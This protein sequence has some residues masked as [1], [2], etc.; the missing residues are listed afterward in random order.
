MGRI[1]VSVLSSFLRYPRQFVFNHTSSPF[2]AFNT[3]PIPFP[4]FV[5]THARRNK[6]GLIVDMQ[7]TGYMLPS[8]SNL[9]NRSFL[10]LAFLRHRL[11]LH[12]DVSSRYLQGRTSRNMELIDALTRA[13]HRRSS[14]DPRKHTRPR[15]SIGG[16][17][18]TSVFRVGSNKRG[19][20]PSNQGASR[21][22]GG[23]P[24][25]LD[26]SAS[27]GVP[28]SR[29]ASATAADETPSTSLLPFIISLASSSTSEKSSCLTARIEYAQTAVANPA[30][31]SPV[32]AFCTRKGARARRRPGDM[33]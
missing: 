14:L 20:A 22:R 32:M 17:P 33:T 3:T 12:V 6:A 28:C 5:H 24:V 8:T 30:R 4:L 26:D 27:L 23:T 16:A 10:Q 7:C 13:C 25:N 11:A 29:D 19:K 1:S 31:T 15:S 21:P 18:H 9:S 2:V